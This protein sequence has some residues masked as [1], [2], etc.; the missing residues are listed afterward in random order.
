M[1]QKILIF[2]LKFVSFGGFERPILTILRVDEVALSTFSK[3][4]WSCLGSVWALLSS[5]KGLLL[6]FF[7]LEW[8]INEPE[9]LTIHS[10][11]GLFWRFLAVILAFW[12]SKKSFSG[13]FQS[14]FGVVQEVF[15][16]FLRF[17][18]TTFW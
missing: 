11:I 7:Q 9:I 1:A 8:L 12:G 15:R 17:K 5:L 2:G 10:K 6:G 16:H 14:C 3:L 13:L 18:R 4:C